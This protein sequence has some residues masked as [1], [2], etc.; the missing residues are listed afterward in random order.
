MNFISVC[1][2][3]GGGGR[4]KTETSKE[5]QE[6]TTGWKDMQKGEWTYSMTKAVYCSMLDK[7]LWQ[8]R[9]FG[10]S[11]SVLFQVSD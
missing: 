1:R 2:T 7:N 11:G 3:S 4:H 5:T 9:G 10:F 8:E 6:Y